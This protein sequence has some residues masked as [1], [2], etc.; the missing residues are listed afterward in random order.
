MFSEERKMLEV[1]GLDAFYGGA[2][3]LWDVTFNVKEGEM[4]TIIGPNGAGK[5]TIV[6]AIAG[7]ISSTKGSIKF[8][9][10]RIDKLPSHEIVEVGITLIPEGRQ[11]FPR[12]TVRDNLLLGAY[13]R[14]SRKEVDDSLQRVY[15]LFPIL[16]ERENQ[17]G[18]TLSGGEQQMLAIGRGLMSNPKLVMLDEPSMGLAPTLVSKT[19]K[20]L[21]RLKDEEI[22]ILLVEQ[23][24]HTALRLSDDAYVLESGRI[25]L[26]GDSKSLLKDEHVKRAYLGI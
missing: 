14:R 21:E 5:T 17:M 1:E 11:V 15:K 8:Q 20:T 13:T 22:T 23:N 3:V 19:F 9:G 24:V 26:K 2:Q 7:L 25:V 12:I 4:T 6:K 10:K 18:G 16:R